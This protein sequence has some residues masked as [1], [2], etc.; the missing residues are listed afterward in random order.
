MIYQMLNEKQC[1][2]MTE[3]TCRILQ[4][5]GCIIKNEAARSL[6][7]QKGCKVEGELVKIPVELTKWAIDQAP[8]EITLYGRDKE[9][10]ME[11]KPG[12][13]YIGPAITITQIQDYETGKRRYSTLQDSIHS[14]VIMDQLPNI[15]WVSALTSPSD[16]PAGV[17]DI[18]ELAVV[19]SYT[20]KPVMYWSQSLETLKWQFQMFEAVGGGAEEI[21][22]K[23]F[24]INLICPMDPLVHTEDGM[25]QILYLAERKSPIV[26]IAGIGIGLSG[27]ATIAGSVTLGMADTLAGLV[28][29]QCVNPGTP[30][31]VSKFSDNV[32][33]RSMCI[34]HSNPEMQV[35]LSATADCFRYMKLPFCSNFGGTDSGEM[36]QISMFDKCTQL[37]TALLSGT[38]MN[39][40]TG[41]YE[42]GSYSKHADLVLANEIFSYLK[43][44]VQN[45]EVS[46]E[47]L[48]EEVIEEVGPGGNFISEE[49][50]L[51]HLYDFWMADLMKPVTSKSDEAQKRC[52][53]EKLNE[54]VKELVEKG[55]ANPLD[56]ER[57]EQL[58]E[59]F[60]KAEQVFVS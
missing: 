38:N 51:D 42:S 31:V 14:T 60:Q 1:E 12:N 27:P 36:D 33:F 39:F 23:P 4:N 16:I 44:L 37:Y 10:A 13:V 5:T 17:R 19:L 48:A 54:R 22:K 7:A 11:L 43:V 6:L 34:T 59:I 53:E 3:S 45:M 25:A 26:Y 40:A 15:S 30:F 49:H 56:E 57:K 24:M 55:S 18:A 46:E 8:S 32:D 58:K 50:T 2:A 29:A 35:A 28:V 9:P 20:K 41:A 21:Q 47:T 52:L